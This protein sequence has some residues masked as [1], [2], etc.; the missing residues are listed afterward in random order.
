MKSFERVSL[1]PDGHEGGA[2]EAEI[3]RQELAYLASHLVCVGIDVDV[4]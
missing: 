4:R 2:V 1:P 3:P